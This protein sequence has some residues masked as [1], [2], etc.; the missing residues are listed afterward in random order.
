MRSFT[1]ICALAAIG[2]SVWAEAPH[3]P[4]DA[5]YIV[6][7]DN[8]DEPNGYGFCLDTAG[9]DL[10]DFAQ[11]HTCKPAVKDDAGNPKPNDTQFR[12][13]GDTMRVESVAYPGV[14]VQV[15]MSPYMTAFGLLDCDDHPRQK[16][17]LSPDDQTLR[18]GEDPSQCVS[19]VSVTSAAG[20]WSSRQLALTPCDTTEDLLKQWTFVT[21]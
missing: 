10:S 11:A 20:P 4:S 3:V 17:V 15:L 5:P 18:M 6:L 1:L 7:A 13:D 21:E 19:V 2:T 16:F 12:Y 8:L 9:R 14:C